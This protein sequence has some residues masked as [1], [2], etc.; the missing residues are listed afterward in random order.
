MI[1]GPPP[2]R[3]ITPIA[4]ALLRGVLQ[5]SV[6]SSTTVIL[7]ASVPANL[8]VLAP[9]KEVPVIVTEVPPSVFPDDG[10]IFVIVGGGGVSPEI[11]QLFGAPVK[12][13]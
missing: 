10:E 3:T 11:V 2:V 7:V 12:I 9:V 6:V 5:V 13:L 8:T 4:P 1:L